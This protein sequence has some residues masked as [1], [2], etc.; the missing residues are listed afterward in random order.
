[1]PKFTTVAAAVALAADRDA[2]TDFS[3][4]NGLYL[5]A[6]QNGAASWVLRFRVQGPRA[7]MGLGSATGLGKHKVSMKAAR[8]EANRLL[9]M[10]H[11]DGVDPREERRR[12]KIGDTFEQVMESVIAKE[13]PGWKG[14]LTGKSASQWRQSLKDHASN[15]MAMRVVKITLADVLAILRPIWGTE[16][17]GRVQTRIEAVLRSAKAQGLVDENVGEWKGKLDQI[18][19]A[20]SQKKFGEASGEGHTSLP[21]SDLQAFIAMLL[22]AKGKA[23]KAL[24]FCIL[25]A[26]RSGETLGALKSEINRETKTWTIPAARMKAGEDHIVP[27]S[28]QA[29]EIVNAMWGEAGDHLFANDG[30]PLGATALRDK[31][32]APQKKGG[33][34]MRAVATVHGFRATFSTW[35]Q[36][37][38]SFKNEVIEMCLAHAVKVEMSINADVRAA[39]ARGKCADMRRS[40][41]QAWAN[42]AFGIKNK[43]MLQLV[44]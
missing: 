13:A 1:M 6:N 35:A 8:Q 9:T 19:A 23:V 42:F 27:L 22:Q 26:T 25:T 30:K 31:L 34:D 43:V 24:L 38:T 39:Y 10:L 4:G 20:K 11:E 32:Q 28:D 44:A 14:G 41:M 17:A 33:F 12:A 21:Y 18:L 3:A 7:V 15:L 16:T 2:V 40:A 5:I 29:M 36:E 37:Q